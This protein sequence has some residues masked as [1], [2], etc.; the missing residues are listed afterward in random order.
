MSIAIRS[1]LEA[2][3]RYTVRGAKISAVTLAMPDW[4]I[5]D[6]G[7]DNVVAVDGVPTDAAGPA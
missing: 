3:L 5:D 7:P 4:Q 6:V 1:E 2:T